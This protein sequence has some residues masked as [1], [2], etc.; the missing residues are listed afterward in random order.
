MNIFENRAVQ[1]LEKKVKVSG[2][3]GQLYV[4][5]A[6]NKCTC[7]RRGAKAKA[8]GDE[9]VSV[10]HLVLSLIR[11]PNNDVKELFREFGITRER[12]LQV[13]STIRGNIRE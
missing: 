11:Y 13:L 3:N 12:F 4:S 7:K 5:N 9:Y 8:M 10:E 1:T 6:L 2:G